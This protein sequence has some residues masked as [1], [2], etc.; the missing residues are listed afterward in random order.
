MVENFRCIARRAVMIVLVVYWL[1]LFIGTHLPSP[2]T[3]GQHF[4]DKS[5]HF[6]A[7]GGLGFLLSWTCLRRHRTWKGCAAVL[8]II[9]I[10]G[11]A[12]E[13]S[14][15]LVPPRAAEIGD[16]VADLVGGLAGLSLYLI[17]VA[18]RTD[19]GMPDCPTSTLVRKDAA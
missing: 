11:I 5:L 19:R 3:R 2:P 12:D 10:Y 15:I 6:A 8:A 16:W 18:I 13:A 7:Y 9:A 17:A 4:N 14:Q 1:T